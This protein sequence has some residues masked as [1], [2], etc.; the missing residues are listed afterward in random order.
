[1]RYGD[2]AAQIVAAIPEHEADVVLLTAPGHH[3]LARAWF[4]SVTEGVV[5]GSP[6]PVLVLRGDEILPQWLG[7]ML[8]PLDASPGS[9]ALAVARQLALVLGASLVLLR[10]IPPLPRWGAVGTSTPTGRRRWP[11]GSQRRSRRSPAVSCAPS[12]RAAWPR[13]PRSSR[14]A[15][16]A[17][18]TRA[19]PPQT[20]AA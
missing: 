1:M 19:S 8:I 15:Q 2:A 18:T 6:L 12:G 9:A 3:G 20:C 5:A 10:V 11:R 4:G 13:Q 14:P 17:P 7:T 16:A